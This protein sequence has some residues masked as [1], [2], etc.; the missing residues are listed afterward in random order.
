M[1]SA[2]NL[3]ILPFSIAYAV[4]LSLGIECFLNVLAGGFAL[5]LDGPSPMQLYPRFLPFCIVTGILSLAAIVVLFVIN[6][7]ASDRLCF[8]KKAW[9]VQMILACLL[10]VPMIYP[11]DVL[12][13]LLHRVF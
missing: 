6:L 9:Y 4:F 3:L 7:K 8:S 13:D 5:S 11:W 10:S 2:K 1:K 12:F